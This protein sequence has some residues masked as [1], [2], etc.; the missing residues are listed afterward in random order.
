METDFTIDRNRPAPVADD[1]PFPQL[2]IH[3][4][5]HSHFLPDDR[6]ILVYLPPGYDENPDR[7]YP[8]LYLHDGQNLFDPKT[9]FIPGRTWRVHE[10][11]DAEILAGRVEPLLIVGLHN[12]GARRMAEYTH[13]PD[14]K[15]G[16]GEAEAYG[17]LFMRELLPFIDGTYRTRKDPASTGMG[18][19]SLGGLVTLFL[20]L[21]YADTFGKLAVLSPSVWWNH[22]SIVGYVNEVSQRRHLRP[23]IWLDVGDAEG[24]RTLEDAD[25]L[26][27]R[28]QANGWRHGSELHYERVHGG[29]H[30]EAAWS[31][32]VAPM[33]RFLFPAE[34]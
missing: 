22:K 31:K 10:H 29:T 18:G 23:R 34:K 6:D 5:W 19:S 26:N 30:D 8:V 21:K 33:L 14:W 16:G 20:G 32:R 3:R 13:T 25:L 24:K 4:K 1:G 28:L 11:A 2:K 17:K 7:R 15:M 9:S 12:A 27:R